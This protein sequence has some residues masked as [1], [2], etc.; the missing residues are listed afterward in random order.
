MS[1][2]ILSIIRDGSLYL[3]DLGEWEVKH[4][5]RVH[6]VNFYTD[7]VGNPE[8]PQKFKGAA[9]KAAVRRAVAER[10]RVS[11]PIIV[12]AI[13]VVIAIAAFL[14]WQRGKPK[15]SAPVP[16][17]PEK[18]IAVLPF[19]NRSRDPDNAYFTDGVQDEILNRLG[20]D[21]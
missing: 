5:V 10:R 1:P 11:P 6:A 17:I 18:S 4:G 16:V 12:G 3:H 15:T 7:E 19:E 20:K 14:F 2:K 21:R 8:I 13:L 9:V